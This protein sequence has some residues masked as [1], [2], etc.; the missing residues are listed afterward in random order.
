MDSLFIPELKVKT[1]LENAMNLLP[2][3]RFFFSRHKI[4]IKLQ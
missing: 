1:G 3:Y 2:L 4:H